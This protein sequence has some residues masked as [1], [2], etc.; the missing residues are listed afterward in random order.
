MTQI[1]LNNI[2]QQGGYVLTP[3]QLFVGWLVG[4]IVSRITQKPFNRFSGK[5]VEG[6]DMG[7][8]ETHQLWGWIQ[9]IRTK[10]PFLKKAAITLGWLESEYFSFSVFLAKNFF[11]YQNS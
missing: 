11:F 7:P 10:E 9:T 6:W 1:I 8:D 5:L 4:W 2:L 3:V